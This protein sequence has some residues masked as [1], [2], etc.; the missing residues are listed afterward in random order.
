MNIKQAEAAGPR[1]RVVGIYRQAEKARWVRGLC[2]GA[3]LLACAP[4]LIGQGLPVLDAAQ[5][6]LALEKLLVVG[7][8]LYLGAHPDDE[9]TAMLA[10]LAQGRKVCTGYL[11]LTRGDGGQ[12]LIGSEKGDALGVIRTQELLAARRVDGA[13]QLFT[14]AS[15]FGF[16]KTPGETLAVWGKEKT[17]ADVVW[18]IRSFR[19]DIIITRFP[20]TG[21]GGHGHHTASA[22]L[23]VE[24][25]EAAGDPGRFPE[26]LRWVS[27]W[28]PRRL[29]WNAWVPQGQTRPAEAPELLTVDLGTYDQLLGQAY[30]ELAAQ[31]RSM[32][33]SQGFGAPA[34][35]GT[36]PNYLQL[37]AG[38][39]ARADPFEGIDLTW[40]R[41]AGGDRVREHLQRALDRLSDEAPS[42]SVASLLSALDQIDRLPSGG[43]LIDRK[44]A[45][46]VDAIR[47]CCGIWL[48]AVIDRPVV[49]PGASTKLTVSALKREPIPVV[50]KR[51]EVSHVAGDFLADQSLQDNL[52]AVKEAP[53]QI[54]SDL[55]YTHPFWLNGAAA[56]A[57]AYFP[58]YAGRASN[59]PAFVAK[60]FLLVDGHEI[61]YERPVLYRW[62]D[63]VEGERYREIAVV[64]KITVNLE[65]QALIFP[66]PTERAFRLAARANAENAS[67]SIVI[68]AADGWRVHP[69]T[70]PLSFT[71]SGEEK[72]IQI[73]ITPPEVESTSE[74]KIELR[75]SRDEPA[76]SLVEI[77]YAHIPPQTLL[78]LA[79]SKLVR[80]DMA[81]P[82]S[83]VGYVMGSGDE[84]PDVLRQM[85]FEVTLLSDGD[86]EQNRLDRF[87][88]IVVGVRA[89][90]TRPRL[91]ALQ[92]QLFDYAASGGTLIVQYNT[93]RDLVTDRLAP[94]PLTLSRDRVTDERS[95]VTLLEPEHPL[96]TRPLKITAKDFDGW[97]QERGLYFPSKWD[98]AF[99]PLLAMADPDEKETRGAL[100]AA[101][102]GKGVYIYTGLS[103]FRQL[104][105][106]VPG[107]IRLFANLL[108]GG[109]N[110]G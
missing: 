48:E 38:E 18:V 80:V 81:A 89:F 53:I 56:P 1:E 66:R 96:L 14:R 103:F 34:R 105:A 9:N 62:T 71:T 74:L 97:I 52:L 12:N 36:W 100:L 83:R 28:R 29:F 94:Y 98:P 23:A 4:L 6:R 110:G 60:F 21:D 72:T 106:G 68:G 93:D 59:P 41:I 40:H 35:R 65:A 75:A 88:A 43:P 50:C 78:P 86:I 7:S 39:P 82:R 24:A 63:P 46:V 44:R 22:M 70:V 47:S 20:T 99:V 37:L 15:D 54:P 90:N 64:P 49:S 3:A 85:G 26:Q 84:I 27:P 2:A 10:Y 45:E 19:P 16:S 5:R 108:S 92:Q 13:E 67:G 95:P 33:K 57:S 69:A 107:A 32:H 79:T 25:F 109:R 61:T 101:P 31:A 104:P 42:A 91:S 55:P 11:S 51:V 76:H 17:L 30:T 102:C 77:N 87:D 8:A 58:D 73:R